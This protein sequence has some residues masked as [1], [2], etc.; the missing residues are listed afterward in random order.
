M[1]VSYRGACEC[2]GGRSRY[3][4]ECIGFAKARA[5][6]LGPRAPVRRVTSLSRNEPAFAASTQG[7]LWA[8]FSAHLYS[9]VAVTIGKRYALAAFVA[10]CWAVSSPSSGYP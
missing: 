2:S 6:R 9:A 10:W 4:R 8:L 5:A 7:P 3:G 1:P